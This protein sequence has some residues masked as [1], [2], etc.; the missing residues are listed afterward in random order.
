MK[1]EYD[2]SKLKVKK[3]GPVISKDSKVV[4]TIR[5]DQ[6]VLNWLIEE[7]EKLGIGYQTL[8][9]MKLRESMASEDKI[10]DILK[11]LE[12]IEKKVG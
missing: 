8:L 11:R 3:R 5:L 12:T 10:N 9:G 1:K 2:L 7:A 4:K 6:D